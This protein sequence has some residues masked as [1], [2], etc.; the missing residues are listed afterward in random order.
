[1]RNKDW[2]NV[3]SLFDEFIEE[4][5][6]NKNSF[7]TDHKNIL[8][9]EIIDKINKR[10]VDNFDATKDKNFK[11]KLNEQFDG[12]SIEERQVFA[13]AEWLWAYSVTDLNIGRKLSYT[14]NITSISEEEIKKDKYPYGFGSAGQF[15]KTNK[16]WEISFNIRLIKLLLEKSDE[17]TTTDD[18][19]RWIEAICLEFKYEQENN[20]IT[21]PDDF[22]RLFQGKALAMYNILSYCAYPD[23]YERIASNSHKSQIYNTFKGL[24]EDEEEYEDWNTDECI[25]KIREKLS[26]IKEPGF[27]FY[28]WNYQKLWNYSDA[29]ISYDELQAL[30]YKKAIVLYG[31]PGT[32]KTYSTSRIATS[33][34]GNAYLK[35][36]GD[37]KKYFEDPES[38]V[39]K[40][41]HRLQLHTNYNY[42][43][44]V[45]GVQ[46][47]N[48]ETEAVKGK[49]FDIC[50]KAKVDSLPH[51]L[52]LDE[53]NRVDLS[54][55]FGEV[56]SAMEDRSK[57]INTA[58][59]N[60]E[61]QIPE[62]LYIIGTMN[63]I[64]FSLERIDFALRR[65]FLWF[66]YTFKKEVLRDLIIGKNEEKNTR[67]PEEEIDQFVIAAD[68]LNDEISKS[69]ELGNQFKIGHT[70]FAEVVDIYSSY[71]S[72]NNKHRKMQ[73]NLYRDGGPAVILWDISIKPMIEAFLGNIDED[74]KKEELER[75]RKVYLN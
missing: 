63:E 31:P 21:I 7:L 65:R 16:F 70:F 36:N 71:R 68:N 2:E 73:K 9:I 12:A 54:R 51:L 24:I 27:D 4:F 32:G 39:E 44:F 29:D 30:N 10:F 41:I 18:L 45:A 13:H 19:K 1:M 57:S 52:I 53:I 50:E 62:N 66:E 6:I 11:G 64:D 26:E 5:L 15:H 43:D 58:I 22:K 75:L 3:H 42:E 8:S 56:F 72:L 67:I 69:S 25:L 20:I 37:L 59:G 34:I 46:L 49:L 55:L 23:K 48:E 33:F 14:L 61:L 60:F 28:N 47:K 74:F 40:R 17:V 38:I 35:Q